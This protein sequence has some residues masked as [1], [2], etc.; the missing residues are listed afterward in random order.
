MTTIVYGD[1]LVSDDTSHFFP[2]NKLFRGIL[3]TG[4]LGLATIVYGDENF[5]FSKIFFLSY[6]AYIN[7]SKKKSP[8]K[9]FFFNARMRMSVAVDLVSCRRKRA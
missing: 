6:L 1:E 9:N 8:K 5:F 3:L 7:R 4:P 2:R